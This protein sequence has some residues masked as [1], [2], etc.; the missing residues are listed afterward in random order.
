[1]NFAEQN[2]ENRNSLL[3]PQPRFMSRVRN[4]MT[5]NRRCSFCN[6]TGHNITS[7]NDHR[8]ACFRDLCMLNK[9][10]CYLANEPRRIFKQLLINYYI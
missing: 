1:M 9:G 5:G 2:A 4:I 6:E 10:L 7:C 3:H 8:L